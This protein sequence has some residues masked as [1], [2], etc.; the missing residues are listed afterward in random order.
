MLVSILLAICLFL[1]F[2][3]LLRLFQGWKFLLRLWLEIIKEVIKIVQI[4]FFLARNGWQ[5]TFLGLSS[6]FGLGRLKK[7]VQVIIHGVCVYER[8]LLL[9]R[10][11]LSCLIWP[12][13]CWDIV[14]SFYG[15]NV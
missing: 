7:V 6:H 12:I 4:E 13:N 15:P 9:L 2:A 8:F 1:R 10:Y 14:C 5:H 3:P 11:P